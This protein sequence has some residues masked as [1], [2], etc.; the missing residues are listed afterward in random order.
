VKRTKSSRKETKE[1][2]MNYEVYYEIGVGPQTIKDTMIVN[3]DS[4]ER[5]VEFAG[6][7]LNQEY[8]QGE[9]QNDVVLLVCEV[10]D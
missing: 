4:K 9:H 6:D 5:A 2:A 1:K 10:V 8:N 7:T 3:A